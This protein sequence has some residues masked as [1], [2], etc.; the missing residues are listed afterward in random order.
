M[1]LRRLLLISTLLAG[2]TFAASDI[3]DPATLPEK[4]SH[5]DSAATYPA[6]AARRL[7]AG[8]ALL[9]QGDVEKARQEFAQ[10]L[11]ADDLQPMVYFY[12]A[13]VAYRLGDYPRALERANEGSG[14]LR[15]NEI[16]GGSTPELA[17]QQARFAELEKAIEA[18]L[19]T[20]G[21]KAGENPLKKKQDFEAALNEGDEAYSKGLLAKAAAAYARAFRADP[22]QGEIGLR[23]ASLFADRLKN[24]LDAAILWQQVLAAGEPHATTARAELQ[25]HHDALAAVLAG[26]LQRVRSG[27]Q[28]RSTVNG[29]PML[30]DPTEA[31]RLAE[32]FPESTELQVEIAARYAWPGLIDDIL[33]HLQ[34]ASR[35]GLTPDEFLARKEFVDYLERVG[36]KDAGAQ[37]LSAF[38]RDAYGEETLGVVRTEL[39]RR[40][41]ETARLAREKAEKERQARVAKE[42]KEL[43]AWRDGE[44]SKTM[45][46]MNRLLVARD[47]IAVEMAETRPGKKAAPRFTNARTTSFSLRSSGGYWLGHSL[48]Y[49]LYRPKG[50]QTSYEDARIQIRSFASLRQ[51]EWW[52]SSWEYFPAR[53]P[54]GSASVSF[55][56]ASAA[57]RELSKGVSLTFGNPA[58]VHAEYTST[59]GAS[60]ESTTRVENSASFVSI[61]ALLTDDEAMRLKQLFEQLAKLDAAG[62][63]AEKLRR[64]RAAN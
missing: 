45:Q 6:E 47:D 34:A 40:A 31:L 27:N 49:V 53:L 44:R 13:V 51:V 64:L 11:K 35:L 59:A 21:G 20:T 32:A 48:R 10:A 15:D 36:E 57:Q 63:D 25:S 52:P 9:D 7:L 26:G 12:Q 38:V 42:L 56:P 8:K 22:T 16:N 28:N 46:E 39:K 37:R 50:A 17:A 24:P 43:T 14:V 55:L 1:R 23:A 58:D 29:L 54:R 60:Q 62:N 18:K 61:Q 41:E 4:Q 3:P 33:A 19:A 5:G 30:I 2:A